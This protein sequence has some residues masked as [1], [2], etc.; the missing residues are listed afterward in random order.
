MLFISNYISSSF[1]PYC[2]AGYDFHVKRC[3][4]RFSPEVMFSM[5]YFYLF[6]H[7]S[8]MHNLNS[9][10]CLCRLTGIRRVSHQLLIIYSV[11][12]AVVSQFRVGQS[13]IL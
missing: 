2:Y 9:G 3:P 7:T 11:Q 8:V 13:L 4:V 12:N 1:V 5:C 6:L 10:C